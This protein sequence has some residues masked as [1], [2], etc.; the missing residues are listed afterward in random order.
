MTYQE[1]TDWIQDRKNKERFISS[2]TGG[3]VPPAWIFVPVIYEGFVTVGK[4]LA[5]LMSEDHWEPAAI[6]KDSL[7]VNEVD[8]SIFESRG[9][10]HLIISEKSNLDV[11]QTNTLGR[12]FWVIDCN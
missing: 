3:G 2:P 7:Y 11:H 5:T 12:T 4:T 6:L 10:C 9:G 8:V 1:T